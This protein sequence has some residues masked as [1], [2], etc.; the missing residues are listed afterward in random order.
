MRGSLEGRLCIVL[1]ILFILTDIVMIRVVMISMFVIFVYHRV[2]HNVR[3]FIT[4][5]VN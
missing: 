1:P 3:L 4:V 5:L 2:L